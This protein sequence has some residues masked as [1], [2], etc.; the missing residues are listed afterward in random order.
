MPY[1]TSALPLGETDSQRLLLSVHVGSSAQQAPATQPCPRERVFLPELWL[2]QATAIPNHF[3]VEHNIMVK[4]S[5]NEQLKQQHMC[6][7]QHLWS[8]HF[9]RQFMLFLVKKKTHWKL[10]TCH[11]LSFHFLIH[12][13]GPPRYSLRPVPG[14]ELPS[15]ARRAWTFSSG[16]S[17]F[18][19]SAKASLGALNQ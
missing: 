12:Q 13:Q 9:H 7:S 15:G 1:I 5:Q 16:G 18:Q 10:V 17:L 4:F 19:P 11:T 8:L 6:P 14:P 2:S 3:L